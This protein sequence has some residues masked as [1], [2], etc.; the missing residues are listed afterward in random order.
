[1]V[2]MHRAAVALGTPPAP[3]VAMPRVEKAPG[4]PR[5]GTVRRPITQRAMVRWPMVRPPAD[6]TTTVEPIMVG[7]IRRLP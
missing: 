5:T 6:T 2:V 7:I 3:M 4:A 1:M